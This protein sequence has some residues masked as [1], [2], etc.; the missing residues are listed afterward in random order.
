M[1]L[2]S[3]ATK[4]AKAIAAILLLAFAVGA[5]KMI[6]LGAVKLFGDPLG[7]DAASAIGLGIYLLLAFALLRL[8]HWH[9][10]SKKGRRS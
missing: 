3:V 6:Q 4:V 9:K 2:V 1:T 7:F 5:G 8:A 10:A